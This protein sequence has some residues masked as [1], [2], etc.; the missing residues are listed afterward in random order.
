MAEITD[1][2]YAHAKGVCKELKIKQIRRISWFVGLKWYIIVTWCIFR[3]LEISALKCMNLML[4]NFF[5]ALD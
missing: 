4:Q 1:V 2:D 3:A 5:Q